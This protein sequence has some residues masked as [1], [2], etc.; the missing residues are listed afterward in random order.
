MRIFN[1]KLTITTIVVVR[2]CTV[3]RTRILSIK[4]I[5]GI[6]RAARCSIRRWISRIISI[7]RIIIGRMSIC[8]VPS[9]VFAPFIKIFKC[10]KEHNKNGDCGCAIQVKLPNKISRPT[11]DEQRNKNRLENSQKYLF[12]KRRI[13]SFSAFNVISS[14]HRA[15]LAIQYSIISKIA[16]INHK[17]G[18]F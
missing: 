18:R 8:A 3:C 6:V 4:M 10:K 5:I 14:I 1:K 17:T 7:A 2:K 15:I 16:L 13:F 11:S 12:K 9:I